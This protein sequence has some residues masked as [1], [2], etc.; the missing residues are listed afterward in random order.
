MLCH[1]QL[2][3]ASVL[4]RSSCEL[5]YIMHSGFN[6]SKVAPCALTTDVLLQWVN[7]WQWS[8][9]S[10]PVKAGPHGT[11]LAPGSLSPS[12][13]AQPVA[14]SS[15]GISSKASPV[16]QQKQKQVRV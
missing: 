12:P 5:H 1:W 16:Q 9:C 4:C 6:S 10:T 15:P 3:L 14:M 8:T 13:F 7:L 11:L 2:G